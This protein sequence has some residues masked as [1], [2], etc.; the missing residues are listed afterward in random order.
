MGCPIEQ[1]FDDYDRR[2]QRNLD[3]QAEADRLAMD[4]EFITNRFAD[5]EFWDALSGT[6]KELNGLSANEQ[7][8]R[9]IKAQDAIAL[10]L[11]GLC[12]GPDLLKALEAC[13]PAFSAWIERQADNAVNDL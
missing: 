3:L 2:N 5:N 11:T 10:Y 9:A 8:E 1:S 6:G 12:T 7:C 13:K 4:R